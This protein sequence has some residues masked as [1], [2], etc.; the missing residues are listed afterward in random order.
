MK[1][2]GLCHFC[3]KSR[4]NNFDLCYVCKESIC[5][6]CSKYGICLKHYEVLSNAQ[7]KKIKLNSA[8]FIA[9]GIVPVILIT[10]F[11]VLYSTLNTKFNNYI[12]DNFR[13]ESILGGIGI[14]LLSSFIFCLA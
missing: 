10:I 2:K 13:S 6:S 9:F 4:Y 3:G 12:H 8:S 1:S 11:I 7:K 5:R 14:A